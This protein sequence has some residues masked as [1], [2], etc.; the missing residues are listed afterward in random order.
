MLRDREKN[1]RIEEVPIAEG[2]PLVER[3][4][5]D[6]DFRATS[7]ALL[8][9]CREDGKPWVYNPPPSLRITPGLVLILMGSPEDM[10][11]VRKRVS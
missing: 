10:A 2:S 3:T 6:V 8:L 9:A 5:E 11:A 4:L 7:S 1:L